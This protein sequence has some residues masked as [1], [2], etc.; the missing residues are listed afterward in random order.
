MIGFFQEKE[1]ENSIMRVNTSLLI[2][3]GLLISLVTTFAPLV[4]MQIDT[5]QNYTF[6]ITLI[7]AGLGGKL[8]QK[9]FEK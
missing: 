9:P 4:G 5:G 8:I 3:A 2:W 7:T 6:A 1:N